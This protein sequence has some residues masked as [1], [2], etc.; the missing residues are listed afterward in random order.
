MKWV[1]IYKSLVKVK[2]KNERESKEWNEN[3]NMNE[4][5]MNEM[6][7]WNGNVKGESEV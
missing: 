7:E 5:G 1:L 2:G 4:N 6:S 3:Q